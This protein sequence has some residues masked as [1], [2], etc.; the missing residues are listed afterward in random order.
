[1]KNNIKYFK[2]TKAFT[3]AETLITLGIIGIISAITTPT[4]ITKITNVHNSAMLKEDYAILQQMMLMANDKGAIGESIVQGNNMNEMREWFETYFSPNIKTTEVCYN[5]WGC[6]N[7]NVKTPDGQKYLGDYICGEKTISFILNNGSYICMDDF[8]DSRF[9][10]NPQA[11]GVNTIGLL[12]D[13]N[14]DKQPNTIGKDIFVMVFKEDKL[15]PGG[16]DMTEAQIER[17]CST[18]SS[19][20]FGGTYCMTKV[21]KQNFKLPVIK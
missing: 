11:V 12:V 2:K 17:N 16:Y 6:W 7:K 10:V 20:R 19:G 4:L 21:L 3:L 14:G 8:G 18:Q 9:G 1:M 5:Q 13:I 15:L